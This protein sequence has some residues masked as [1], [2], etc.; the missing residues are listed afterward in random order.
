MDKKDPL[1]EELN[2]SLVEFFDRFTSWESSV[3]ES[4]NLKI[5]DAHAIEI[6]G[7]YGRMNMKELAGKLGITTGTTTIT[8]D[9]LEREGYAQRVRAE[10]D[11]R[12]YII[13]LTE[14]GALAYEEHHRH[15]LN[16]ASE[17][18]SVLG[19]DETRIFI[20]LLKKINEHI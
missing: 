13:E 19:D 7:H 18:A 5:S 20:D 6:L 11:R 4:S 1:K 12:S 10:H 2:E 15:H 16:L 14:D 3:I 17:I 9:R 8:V